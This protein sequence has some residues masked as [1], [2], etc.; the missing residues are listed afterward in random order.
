[1]CAMV[2]CETQPAMQLVA[3]LEKSDPPSRTAVCRAAAVAV[4]RLLFD[5]RALPGGEW[6]ADVDHWLTGRTRKLC[7][8]AR[9]AAWEQVQAVAGI[10]AVVAGAEVRAL[11]PRPT[12]ET[13]SPIGRLPLTG[14]EPADPDAAS[15]IDPRPFGSVVVSI[16]PDP[17]MSLG[18]ACA[19][20]GPTWPGRDPLALLAGPAHAS[21][22]R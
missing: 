18:K 7:R 15:A 9:G 5:P 20:A 14:S 11:V 16:C 19:A 21:T 1:M 22:R 2:R 8:R 12:L 6:A 3:R 17:T 10:T 4:V 13:P